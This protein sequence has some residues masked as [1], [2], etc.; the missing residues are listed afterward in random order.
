M[1]ILAIDP[2]MNGGI[3][4]T[5]NNEVQAIKMPESPMDI[6]KRIKNIRNDQTV[7]FLE[8]VGGYV[9]GNS[10]TAAVKFARHIGNIEMAL[11]A[12]NISTRI[13]TPVKWM[14]CLG[15]LPKNKKERKNK[16][17]EKM[18]QLYPQLKI[19]LATSDA[20]G[21]LTY[22]INFLK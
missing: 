8:N 15:A 16:I 4:W 6:Y 17:K 5:L 1:L 3:A 11:L 7:C 22:G 14:K 13:V 19:T 12:L 2:G 9:P 10:A 20:L 21:I 18:Q